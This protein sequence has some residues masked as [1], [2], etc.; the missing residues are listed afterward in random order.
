MLA[1]FFA[2]S[3][4]VMTLADQGARN[5]L[6]AWA[7]Q[8][9]QAMRSEGSDREEIKSRRPVCVGD[10]VTTHETETPEQ[11]ARA[12]PAPD[13]YGVIRLDGRELWQA[14][15]ITAVGELTIA[16]DEGSL[17]R[18]L[19][20]DRPLRLCA[21]RVSLRNICLAT[22]SGIADRSSP[23]SALLLV[24]AQEL[25]IDGCIFDAGQ[26]PAA[27]AA[28]LGDSGP[29]TAPPTGPALIAWKVLDPSE[30]R[31]RAAVHNTVLLGDGPGLYLVQAVQVVELDNVL[32]IGTSPLVQLATVP[33][34]KSAVVLKL[35]RTTCRASG[36][37]L[38]WVVPEDVARAGRVAIEAC[39]CVFDVVSPGAALF[40]F[41][42][43]SPRT[44]W[45]RHVKLTG[46]GSIAAPMLEVA[47]WISTADGRVTGLDGTAIEVEG[48]FSGPLRFGGEP[49]PEPVDSEVEDFE[50]PRR[51][52]RPPG[53]RAGALPRR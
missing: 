14:S 46:E 31:G 43:G 5:V 36:A 30:K 12:L 2:L 24:Q 20:D 35:D 28:D 15:E 34:E 10:D 13:P 40:E 3:G 44:E 22:A 17:S 8:F 19:I 29:A 42:G 18:I 51:T 41:A 37:L 21:E 4:G 47:A 48:I 53:I 49:G 52:S 50:A 1:A 7:A 11:A 45:L 26:V 9:S 23:R 33:A 16:G 27:A 39:D 25:V 32:K 6:L 38:R